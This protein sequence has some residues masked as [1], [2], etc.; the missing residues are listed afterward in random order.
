MIKYIHTYNELNEAACDILE[1]IELPGFILML[2]QQ[3][4]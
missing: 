3:G 2:T 1:N 4:R